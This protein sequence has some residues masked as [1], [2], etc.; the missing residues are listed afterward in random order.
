MK[1][2]YGALID[3]KKNGQCLNDYHQQ[4]VDSNQDMHIGNSAES[5][6]VLSSEYSSIE[7]LNPLC[8]I[9]ARDEVIGFTKGHPPTILS[10]KWT[11]GYEYV[12]LH[13]QETHR[14]P[15]K[16]WI[17]SGDSVDQRNR[18]ALALVMT[19]MIWQEER[20]GF[21][22]DSVV[23]DDTKKDARFNQFTCD[24]FLQDKTQWITY[25]RKQPNAINI[26]YV[27]EVIGEGNSSGY[28]PENGFSC[29]SQQY[30]E[31][32][33]VI[34]MGSNTAS[35]LLAHEFGHA[36]GLGHVSAFAEFDETNV[37]HEASDFRKYLTEG[38]TFRQV[39]LPYSAVND[40]N[41]YKDVLMNQGITLQAPR[42][43]PPLRGLPTESGTSQD[44][45]RKC[46]LLQ[47]RIWPDGTPYPWGRWA[48]YQL[49][50]SP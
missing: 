45:I 43:C 30:G 19:E 35:H 25:N 49:Q 5:F 2:L 20:Q 27:D 46:P 38:Q 15:V 12:D 21:A 29:Y 41:I 10:V 4:P 39:T 8:Q 40:P 3:G 23:I 24:S 34:V 9:G 1:G 11:R 50:F 14:F 32:R 42:N 48:K 18:A 7:Y 36:F 13:F 26:Y 16:V 37:M 31:H 44:T 28:K 33:D 6:P 17:V 22:F 47:T